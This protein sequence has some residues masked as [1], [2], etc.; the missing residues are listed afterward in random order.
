MKPLER[1]IWL[2]RN[3]DGALLVKSA[4]RE[5]SFLGILDIRLRLG[6]GTVTWT[7]LMPA[8]PSDMAPITRTDLP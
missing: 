7:K 2:A 1:E 5:V 4:V 8:T 6:G 3:R